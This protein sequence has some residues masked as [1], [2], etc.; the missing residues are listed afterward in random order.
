MKIKPF[1]TVF[2]LIF[3]LAGC[4]RSA[5][6]H[7]IERTDL[8]TL[9]IG[10]LEDQ[11]AIFSLEGSRGLRPTGIAM[12]DGLFFISDSIGGKILRFNSFG[13]LLLMIYNEETNPPPLTL[14][15][16]QEGTLVTRWAVPFPLLEPGKITVDSRKHIFVRDR[17]PYDRHGFDP[18][19]RALL[20]SIIL[21]FD[22]DGRFVNSL[23]REGIGGSPFPRIEGLYTTSADELVVICRT[24]AGWYIYWFDSH[25]NFLL[26]V[27]LRNDAIPIPPDRYH[28]I[29]SLDRISVGPDGRKLFIKVD[30]FRNTFDESTNTRTGIE[31]D[32][33]VIWRLNAE[34]GVLE[35]FIDLP[36]FEQ[37]FLELNRRI[38]IKMFY[39]FKGVLSGERIFLS[40][41]QEDGYSILI[42]P[43]EAGVLGE[44]RHGFIR[45]DNEDLRFH[46]FDLSADGILSG[47]LVEDWQVQLVWWRT[48]RFIGEGS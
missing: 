29:P 10:R 19:S 22:A 24:P 23:G 40:F 35:R 37:T 8:F 11:I 30:Y 1:V 33:S 43:F 20:D 26:V 45:M 25:G 4:E 7:V 3:L 34:N 41:P 5:R 39:N 21:H 47:L 12:R 32:S 17:L 48:D 18:E 27:Q 13:D 16:L 14:R 2:F 15:P 38:T 31:P 44:Q 6:N 36:F 46:V 42:L 28:V 9:E